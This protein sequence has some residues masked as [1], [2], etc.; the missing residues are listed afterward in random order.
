MKIKEFLY[1]ASQKLINSGIPDPSLEAEILIRHILQ[2]DRAK[3]FQ[4]LNRDLLNYQE[5][6]VNL[7]IDK[8]I[9]GYPLSYI[10]G[11]REFYGIEL[12]INEGVLIPRQET[13]LLVETAINI[14]KVIKD[15]QIKVADIGTGSGAIAIAVALNISNSFVYASDISDVALNIAGNN[16]KKHFLENKIRLRHGDLL[17][18][19]STKVD[20]ILSNP[21]YIPTNQILDLSKEVLNEPR[22]ALDG[23]IDGL[24]IITKLMKQAAVKLKSRGA[25]IVEISPELS[26]RVIK[27][28]DKY[29]PESKISIL[30]DLMGINRAILV[31]KGLPEL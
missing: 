29:F 27:L 7:L 30:K 9:E 10:T 2:I 26:A 21:P 31:N 14:S 20:I 16:I 15:Q 4:D 3:I 5:N 17:D 18:S 25:M 6:E 1:E 13:E 23:G 19:L 28:A 12:E 11:N 8:R 24:G 22:I